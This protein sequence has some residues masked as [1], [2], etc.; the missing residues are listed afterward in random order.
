MFAL[1]AINAVLHKK[2]PQPAHGCQVWPLFTLMSC[3]V[4]CL[5]F[6][7]QEFDTDAADKALQP[8]IA[9][10]NAD[11]HKQP[12]SA[13]GGDCSATQMPF[14]LRYSAAWVYAAMATTGVSLMEKRKQWQQAVDL[15]QQLLGE[16]R[17]ARF[18]A[19]HASSQ[20]S[21]LLLSS[22]C[23]HRVVFLLLGCMLP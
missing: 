23:I 2:P 22:H 7:L 9:A 6:L 10:I 21:K 20:I 11:L 17:C 12:P 1:A 14:F 5:L 15:L 3:F 18:Q 8:A 4:T 13:C 16:L 19:V